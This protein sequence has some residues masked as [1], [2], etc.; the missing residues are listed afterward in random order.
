MM[1]DRVLL[2]EGKKQIYGTQLRSGRDTGGQWVLEPIEDEA[3]VDAR[4][5][6]VGLP[7]LAEYLKAFGLE[8]KTPA[9]P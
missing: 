3:G 6:A 2:G 7:P 4:R 8:Y 1:E 9:N 5:A